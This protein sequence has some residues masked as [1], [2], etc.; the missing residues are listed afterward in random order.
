M[1]TH[2]KVQIKIRSGRDGHTRRSSTTSRREHVPN[3]VIEREIGVEDNI[4]KDIER[5]QLVWYGHVKHMSDYR[6]PKKVLLWQRNIRRKRGR[7]KLEWKCI[8]HKSMSGR[9]LTPEELLTIAP[10][11]PDEPEDFTNEPLTSMGD[12]KEV[13]DAVESTS[14]TPFAQP[15]IAASKS[16]AQKQSEYRQRIAASRTPAP[17]QDL[18]CSFSD[19]LIMHADDKYCRHADKYCRRQERANCHFASSRDS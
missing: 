18:R 7:P 1:E 4:T 13:Q 11:K 17:T 10:W 3:E 6:L 14:A 9:N 8:I 12:A 15:I 16:K 19:L 5:K 2:R